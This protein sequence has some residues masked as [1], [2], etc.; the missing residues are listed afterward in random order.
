MEDLCIWGCVVMVGRLLSEISSMWCDRMCSGFS[1]Y[2]EYKEYNKQ[3]ILDLININR[4]WRLVPGRSLLWFPVPGPR[5]PASLH[6][7]AA[8]TG[9]ADCVRSLFK[10]GATGGWKRVST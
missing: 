10:Q 7:V 1:E 8:T 9:F 3:R 4:P 2:S 5:C 6:W